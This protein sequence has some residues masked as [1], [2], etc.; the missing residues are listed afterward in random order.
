MKFMTDCRGFYLA[1][2]DIVVGLLM[3]CFHSS[4]MLSFCLA[5]INLH[6]LKQVSKAETIQDTSQL[7][8]RSLL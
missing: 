4:V 5:H 7:L 6:F 1:I 8:G 3:V 2:A